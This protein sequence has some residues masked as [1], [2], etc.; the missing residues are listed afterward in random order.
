MPFLWIGLA[1]VGGYL[2]WWSA[3]RYPALPANADALML[4]NFP[5]YRLQPNIPPFGGTTY[6][7]ILV[8]EGMSKQAIIQAVG[9]K[10]T[11]TE[12]SVARKHIVLPGSTTVP[13]FV[14]LWAVESKYTGTDRVVTPQGL[15][16]EQGVPATAAQVEPARQLAALL[17]ASAFNPTT[18]KLLLVPIAAKQA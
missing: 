8:R 5:A 1:L 14:D 15:L 7:Y 6:G 18:Q 2:W 10:D 3:H 11:D 4:L 9:G 16:E 12:A 17:Y 13:A